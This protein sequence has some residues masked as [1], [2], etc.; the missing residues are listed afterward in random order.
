MIIP[1]RFSLYLNKLSISI[2]MGFCQLWRQMKYYQICR[3]NFFLFSVFKMFNIATLA[4][5]LPH[6]LV[7]QNVK[8]HTSELWKLSTT[9][10]LFLSWQI[11]NTDAGGFEKRLKRFGKWKM[12]FLR[13]IHTLLSTAVHI[14]YDTTFSGRYFAQNYFEPKILM[15]FHTSSDLQK[16]TKI[17][18]TVET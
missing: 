12:H 1:I 7:N 3:V 4:L 11:S 10:F 18:S 5:F 16:K 13:F 14:S 17:A 15:Q 2:K 8:Y 6:E 9:Q